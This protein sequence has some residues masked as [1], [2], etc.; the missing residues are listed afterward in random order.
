MNSVLLLF[1]LLM[2]PKRGW[3]SLAGRWWLR[4]S[5]LGASCSG[6]RCGSHWGVIAN[7][8]MYFPNNKEEDLV[9]VLAA[10]LAFWDPGSSVPLPARDRFCS[11]FPR[12]EGSTSL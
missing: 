7:Q 9:L 12:E 1:V 4:A 2:G 6:W 10:P 8:Q 5:L 11:L 3:L